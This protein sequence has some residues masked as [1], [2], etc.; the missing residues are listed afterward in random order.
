MR[1]ALISSVAL[2]AVVA[3]GCASRTGTGGPVPQSAVSGTAALSSFPSPARSLSATDETGRT[4]SAALAADG[5]FSL[6]LAKGHTYK[7]SLKTDHGAVPLVFPRQ[8]GRL[9]ASFVLGTDGAR[10][11]LGAVHYLPGAPKGGF[12]VL[13][14]AHGSTQQGSNC[15]DCVNDDQQTSCE[16]NGGGEGK[17]SE[18]E[19]APGTESGSA[20]SGGGGAGDNAE[21]ADGSAEMAV[22]DQNAPDQATGCD[23]QDGQQGG[24][25]N[26][27][28]TGEH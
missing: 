1:S 12:H 14:A 3:G 21:Q 17:G 16:D 26:V 23:N 7:L 15:T 27:E 13:V 4:S 2:L 24:N 10:I 8:T 22:G 25:D 28:Q 20:S 11:A 18:G 19:S 9:D 5:G 6:A